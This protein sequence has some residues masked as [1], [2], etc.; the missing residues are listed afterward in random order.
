M[1]E[2]GRYGTASADDG[3]VPEPAAEAPRRITGLFYRVDNVGFLTDQPMQVF[4][5]DAFDDEPEPRQLTTGDG[6][7]F[8]PAWS[9]DGT[10]V[11]VSAKRD[12]GVADTLLRR[13]VRGTRRRRRTRSLV[14]K[15]EG[16]VSH[17]VALPDG[18]VV[19]VGD[20]LPLDERGRPQ[21]EARNSRRLG[22]CGRA[23]SRCG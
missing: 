13:L 6:A 7:P 9:L 16:V 20:H 14:A 17:P 19:V 4:V 11:Y 8:D 21:A 12:W 3:E 18:S 2:A 1:P 23:R 10:S 22:P 5:V 15:I